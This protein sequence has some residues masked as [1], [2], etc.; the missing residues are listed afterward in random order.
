VLRYFAGMSITET[1]VTLGCSDGTVKS[2]AS[3]GLDALRFAYRAGA[4]VAP[5]EFALFD[6]SDS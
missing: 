5:A 2:Q 1:A 4:G 6:G 3:R